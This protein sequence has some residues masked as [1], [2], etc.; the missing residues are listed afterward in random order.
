M[1]TF[2]HLPAVLAYYEALQALMVFLLVAAFFGHAL[3]APID[4]IPT[5]ALLGVGAAFQR[6]HAPASPGRLAALSAWRGRRT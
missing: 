6:A 2:A 5:L 1:Q 3:C 4:A